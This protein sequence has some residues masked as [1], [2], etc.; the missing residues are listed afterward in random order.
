MPEKSKNKHAID[1]K[2][3]LLFKMQAKKKGKDL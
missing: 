2:K 3:Q 1:I